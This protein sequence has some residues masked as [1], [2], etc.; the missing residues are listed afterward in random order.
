MVQ[1]GEALQSVQPSYTLEGICKINLN[2]S[3][4]MV[5][6]FRNSVCSQE[7]TCFF[8]FIN[9]FLTFH[10]DGAFKV[11]TSVISDNASGSSLLAFKNVKQYFSCTDKQGWIQVQAT[12]LQSK[13]KYLDIFQ[14]QVQSL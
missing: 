4:F 9:V 1:G 6:Y 7:T 2:V 10:R 13:S 12:V 14:V 3:D 11:F 8:L 5:S